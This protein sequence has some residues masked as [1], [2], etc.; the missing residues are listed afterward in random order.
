M[1]INFSFDRNRPIMG[2]YC[3]ENLINNKKYIGSSVNVLVRLE[4]HRALLRANIHPNPYLQNA[5]NKHKE[6]NFICYLL[7]AYDTNIEDYLTRKEQNWIDALNSEYNLT[8]DVQRNKLSAE[9]RKK[10][11]DTRRKLFSEGKLIPTKMSPVK[12]YDLD[13]VF[14]KEYPSIKKAAQQNGIHATTI[15]RAIKKET[16]QGS[17]YIWRYSSDNSEILPVFGGKRTKYKDLVKSDEF[18]ETPEVDNPEP[19]L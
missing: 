12:Q 19:S 1:V 14:I 4:K 6:E 13:G 9:S 2:V 5:W 11:A 3:I 7:E 10:Q 8:K 15:I 17:G 16:Q 18:R